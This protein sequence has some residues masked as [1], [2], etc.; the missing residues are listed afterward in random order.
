MHLSSAYKIAK[1]FFNVLLLNPVHFQDIYRF[2][3]LNI[4]Y[5]INEYFSFNQ[6]ANKKMVE[7]C[8]YNV[9]QNV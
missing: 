3:H 5:K 6:I 7:I 8:S 9:V 2:F 1:I 4:S